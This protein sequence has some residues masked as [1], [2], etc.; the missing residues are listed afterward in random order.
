MATSKPVT[1][2]PWSYSSLTSYETC[3]RRHQLIK[4]LKVVTEPPSD[5]MTFGNKV[6]KELELATKGEKG[7]SIGFQNYQPIIDRLRAAPGRKLIEY[8]FGLTKAFKPTTFFGS[9]VWVRG[10][11]D[12]GTVTAKKAT[13]LDHKTGSPKF[14][15]DQL[16]LFAGATLQ[17]FP[18]VEEVNTG[19]LWL[20]YNKVDSATF[21]RGDEA[22]IW[23]D[24]SSRVYRMER[25]FESGDFPPRPSGLCKDWCPVGK[26]HCEFC[27]KD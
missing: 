5:A 10:V 6:H 25:S 2:T 19:Y 18:T 7:L 17:L 12:Y 1:A 15:M 21:V 24:F 3:P 13:I 14:V 20:G 9:D 27:G 26:K 16:K 8:K 22:E 23:A 4:V 11:F